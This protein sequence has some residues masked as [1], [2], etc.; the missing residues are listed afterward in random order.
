MGSIS[1]PSQPAPSV[2]PDAAASETYAK[3]GD[4]NYPTPFSITR[5]E[6]VCSANSSTGMNLFWYFK[7]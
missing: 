6:Q 5:A 7:I 2:D 1:D 4:K 3:N